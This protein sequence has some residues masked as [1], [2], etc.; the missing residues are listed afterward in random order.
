MTTFCEI[1]VDLVDAGYVFDGVFLCCS[2][3]LRDV[4]NEIWDLIESVCESFYTYLYSNPTLKKL[5]LK[6]RLGSELGEAPPNRS[7]TSEA[8]VKN[9]FDISRICPMSS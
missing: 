3:F 5:V 7:S 6:N 4:F 2:F 8:C 1:A 9:A